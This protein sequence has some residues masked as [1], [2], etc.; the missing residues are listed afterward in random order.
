MRL[1]I[2]FGMFDLKYFFCCVLL[3][4]LEILI[5]LFLYSDEND[6]NLINNHYL[7]ESSCFFLGYLLNFIPYLVSKRI[8]E[9]ENTNNLSI[10]D[11]IKFFIIC[12]FLLISESLG[13]ISKIINKNKDED[14]DEDDYED[15]F[16]FIEFLLIF[17][18]PH[19]S[20]V[21]Y[22]HQKFSFF[23]FT[24]IEISKII[25]NLIYFN[26]Y[27]NIL[28]IIL[29]IFI[30]FLYTFYYLYIKGLMKYKF[31]SF[32][33]CNFM[34]GIINFP[35]IIIIYF[36]IS[37]TS[38][39]NE[40]NEYYDDN[41]FKLYFKELDVINIFR[42]VLLPLYYG[43]YVFLFNKIIRYLFIFIIILFFYL[44]KNLDER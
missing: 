42:L 5:Y 38:L 20:E 39:G 12:L 23:I 3:L 37:F 14:E 4:I 26:I 2:S 16:I 28:L 18:I 35:L 29:E 6:R 22:K 24:L 43:I 32:T 8:S 41:I 27:H 44:V 21:Y 31:V 1:C 30:S 15:R 7:L 10:K 34:I 17:L 19:S 9:E 11:I 13:I 33:K 40:N 25:F 36:I